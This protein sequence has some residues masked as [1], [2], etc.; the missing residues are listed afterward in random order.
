M[1]NVDLA[2]VEMDGS[3]ESVFVPTDVEHDEVSD[4][5]CRREGG[6]QGLK[7]RKVMPLH[8]FKPSSKGAFAVGVLLP[9]LA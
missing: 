8:D 4:F 3:D 1:A 5:V 2:P 6:T 9:K 7:A